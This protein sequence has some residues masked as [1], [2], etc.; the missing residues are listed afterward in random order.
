[1]IKYIVKFIGTMFSCFV[2]TLFYI[3]MEYIFY[4]DVVDDYAVQR[5][6]WTSLGML[7]SVR[8]ISIFD[9]QNIARK[10]L[11]LSYSLNE[12]DVLHNV[13][14]FVDQCLNQFWAVLKLKSTINYYINH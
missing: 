8:G 7:Y 9:I 4:T 1:M 5:C 6:L 3:L 10:N 2:V 13:T 12:T 14:L 11:I